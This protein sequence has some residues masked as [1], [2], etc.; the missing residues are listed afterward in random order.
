[1]KKIN[2]FKVKSL[3][4]INKSL[5]KFFTSVQHNGMV[6]CKTSSNETFFRFTGLT[7][8]KCLFVLLLLVEAGSVNATNYYSYQTGNWSSV[9]TWT[10]DPSGTTL[11]N[12]AVPGNNDVI[13]IMPNRTVTLTANVTQ[14]G[15]SI[16]LDEG[17]ILNLSTY[18]TAT[19]LSLSGQG[20]LQLASATFPT[21]TTNTLVNTGGG[22]V[23]YNNTA[24]F[25]LPTGQTSYN[26]LV[27]NLSAGKIATQ[28]N[29]LTLNGDLSVKKGTY[30][31]ND[32]TANRRQLT[33]KGD[34]T[35]ESGASLTVGTGVT[36]STTTPT[37]ITGGTPPF[38]N[39]YNN[40]S[41][42][43]VIN[44]DFTNNGTVRFTN[45]TVPV[46]NAFPPTTVGTTTGFATVYFQGSTDNTV[47]CNG[48]TD[49]Y[50]LVVDK[51]TDKTYVLTLKSTQYN[52]FRLF[53]AN[54]S[55]ADITNATNANPN[56]KKALWLRNGTL[57]LKGLVAIPSLTGGTT[58]TWPSSDFIIPSNAALVLDGTEVVVLSTADDYGEVNVAYGVS[59]GTGSV[60]GVALGGN[61][62]IAVLGKLQINNGY[63]STRESIGITYWSYASGQL[64]INNGML[65]TKQ[66]DDA[67]GSN[68]GLF[69]YAQNNGTVSLRGRFQHSLA[70]S[71]IS[72]LT[73]TA[74]N[75]SRAI[76]G[77]KAT[78]GTIHI[79]TN[80]GSGFSMSGGVMN[81]YDVCGTTTPTYAFYVNSPSANINVTGGTIQFIPITGTSLA[82]ANFLINSAAPFGNLIVNKV[83][84][85]SIVQLNTNPLTVLQSTTIQS[86]TF[87]ANNLNVNIGGNFNV[88]STGVYDS[89]T[90]TTT[91]NG[92]SNQTFTIDGSINNGSA[93]LNNLLINNA[94]GNFK[95][96]GTQTSLTVQGTFD[97][98]SGTL[99]D[100]GKIVYIAGNVTNNGSHTGSGKIQLNGTATQ[101]IGG[102]GSGV[103]QN[104][105]LNNTNA[106]TAPISLTAN[107]TINGTLTFSQAKS[108][109]IGTYGLI[110]NSGASIA[111]AASDRFIQTAG[112]SGDGGITKVYSST[113]PFVFPVG[114][115]STRHTTIFYTPATIGFSSAPT[116]YGSVTVIPVGYEHPA[117][118]QNGQS[119]TYF[120]RIKSS[121]FSGIAT[122]SVTHSFVYTTNDVVGTETKY[123]PSIYNRSNYTWST[124][125][126]ANPPINTTTNTITDATYSTNF[127]DGD[128]TAGDITTNGGAFG[129]QKI[130]YSRQSGLWS[131]ATSWSFTSNT[132]TANTGGVVP[133]A[134]D[135]VV[136]GGNDVITLGSRKTAI[137][138][139]ARNCANLQIEA[140]STL[141]IGNNPGCVFKMVTSHPNGNGNFRLTTLDNAGA[142]TYPNPGGSTFAFPV[143][144]FSE[145]NQNLGTTELYTTN[146]TSGTTYYLPQG[147]TSYG[148]LIIS[149][150]GGSNIIFANNDITIYGNLVTR[151]QN[152]DSWFCP[153]WNVQYPIAP[154]TVVA[155]TITIKGDLL[156][157]GGA[158]VWYGN[159][160]AQN[161]VVNG[162]VVVS[163]GAAIENGGSASNQSLSIGGSLIN[164]T[165]NATASGVSTKS[166][167]D[168]VTNGVIP[169]TFFGS[170]DA[171]ITNTSS[172]PGTI[173]NKVTVNKG[174]S[175]TTTLTCN[176][177]GT[178]TTPTDN[179]L[180]LTNGTFKYARSNPSA[181]A[182][183]TISTGTA[184]TIPATAGLYVNMPSNTNNINVLIANSASNTNDLYLN[185]K[186][187][188]VNGNVYVGP[189]NGTTVNNNDIEYSSGGASAIEV[190]GGNLIVNGS[191][192]RNPANSAGVLSYIQTGGAV[193][194]NGQNALTSNAK[195]EVLNAGSAFNM[196]GGTITIIRGGG[197]TFGDLYLRPT[198][199]SVT[200]GTISFAHNLSGTAQSYGLDANI[201]LNNITITGR[202]T[203]TAANATVN[204]MVSPLVL[205][206]TLL[207][208]NANSI[209]NALN[210]TNSINVTVKGDF[211]NNGTYT[212][213]TNK[214]IFNGGVQQING[215]ST[216]NFYDLQINPIT[217]VTLNGSTTVNH[218]L[219]IN[220]GQ[221]L[222][223][224]N[225]INLKG[226]IT[227]NAS[228]NGDATTG[229][230]ILN[231]PTLQ[232]IAGTGT[233]GRLELNNTMGAQL[234]NNITLQKNFKL[235]TGILD[236]AQYLL[237]LG[238]SSS[239]EGS[240]FSSTKMIV[241]DGVFSNIGIK[242]F[243]S[244]GAST[245]TYPIGTGGKYTPVVLTITANGSVGFVRVNN[246]NAH[247]P[248]VLDANNVL[249]YYW[250]VESSN[251]SGF[252]GNMVFNYLQ[253][254]VKGTETNY[255]AAE[256]M[257]PGTNWSKTT[258][259]NTGTNQI[260]FN[261]LS[262]T[263]TISGQYTGGADAAIPATIPQYISTKT[264]L[265][266]DNTV[267]TPTNGSTY[268]CPAGGP[269]G[270]IVTVASGHVVTTVNYC[271]A[272]QTTINGTLKALTQGNNLGSVYGTG[273]LH[274]ESGS[275]PAGRYTDFFDCGTGGI[276]EFGGTGDYTLVAGYLFASLPKLY[277]IGTGKR[278]MP[279]NDITICT[280]FKIDG[281]TADNSVYNKKIFIGGT[282]ERYNSGVFTSG[283]GSNATVS[284]AGSSAQI[285][286][287]SLGNFSGTNAF[288]N[289][290]INNTAG[291]TLNG[292]TQVKNNLL[293]TAGNITT[294]SANSLT[295]S[296]TSNNC[297]TPAG[298]STTSY[299][300]G[301]LAKT[302]I[303]GDN[304]LFPIGKATNIGNLL[305]L[306]STQTGTQNWTVEYFNPNTYTSFSSPLSSVNSDEY[307]NV[308]STNSGTQQA[309]VNIKWTPS[310]DLNPIMTQSGVSDMTLAKW[311]GANWQ[312]LTSSASGDN[313]N[314]SAQ[315]ISRITIPYTGNNYT[316]GC[317]NQVRPK[318]KFVPTGPVCGTSGIPIN[319]S[320]GATAVAP[321]S[322]SYTINGVDQTPYS[323]T[324]FPAL[325]PTNAAGGVYQITGFTYNYPAG[326]LRTGVFDPTTVT[327]YAIPTTANAGST[328]SLCG[329]T[330]ATLAA[331]T[332]TSGTG[333]W[334]IVSGTGGTVTNPTSPTSTFTGTNGS[335]Y[336]LRW[337][338]SNGTCTSND[339]VVVTFPLLADQPL[340]FT[341]SSSTVCQGAIG[342]VYTVPNDP[343]VTSYNW[344]YSGSGATINGTGNSVTVDF[345]NAATSGT[346]SVTA[347]N[348]CNTST[349]RTINITVN[350]NIWIGTTSS[351][352]WN[353]PT[354]WQAGVVPPS[355][356]DIN[357]ATVPNN[358]LILDGDRTIGNLTN[359]STNKLIIPAGRSL[360]VTNKVTTTN[361][362]QI[363]IQSSSSAPN[364]SLVFTQPTLNSAV[365]ATVEMYSKASAATYSAGKYSN[366]K[367]QYFGI[368]LNSILANPTLAGSYIRI[369]NE[370]GTSSATHW[371]QLHNTDVL[372]SFT[373][374]EI[375]Q[376]VATKI[377]FQGQLVTSDSN[378]GQLSY[379][380][381]SD[382]TFSGQHIFGNPY[383]AAI[384][385]TK[386][387]TSFGSQMDKT[388]YLYNTG[389]FAD[390][391]NNSGISAD[392]TSPGQYTSAPIIWAGTAGIPGQIPS[393]QGF[394]VKALSNSADATFSIPYSSV[395][396]KNTDLQRAPSTQDSTTTDKVYLRITVN[397][398]RFT[399]RMWI[400]SD[401][402]CT[403]SY[404]NGWDG[405]KM[406]GASLSPQLYAI[407]DDG[408]Y[409]VNSVDNI[410]ETYLGFVRGEDTEYKFTFTNENI[411]KRFGNIYL[412]DFVEN[413]VVDITKTGTEYSF[414]SDSTDT[415]VKRFKIVSYLTNVPDTVYKEV[416]VFSSKET[417]YVDNQTSSK[418]SVVLYNMSGVAVQKSNFDPNKITPISTNLP[419]GIYIAK[420]VA[421]SIL[422]SN[423]ILINNP[424]K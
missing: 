232:D 334:T 157:Q 403:R 377:V 244:A 170:N 182:D 179:W 97:L 176:I 212:Y 266:N 100:G 368:P 214:T 118:T 102:S 237:T 81:I 155:K 148:N 400:F 70:Y 382:A 7:V 360:T 303:Q 85:S 200:G 275:L 32:N 241:S 72:D 326:T 151:G 43:V 234:D 409:Q 306:L 419:S 63:L 252:A 171:S 134:D 58:S 167:I 331:N 308:I 173:F 384:D 354:N 404:D 260:T 359:T 160:T 185:G 423:Q 218:N 50:N 319:L 57:N 240:S 115:P 56:V 95:L 40:Q 172:T 371:V 144:D 49:F 288:N 159:S 392:G 137:N 111:N 41:H 251:L 147:V 20:V 417:I 180:T 112:N 279:N 29:N 86:G 213:G 321:F 291:L 388:V 295:I 301:P 23:E 193:T 366:Y 250:E 273:T 52:Y 254:D 19:L 276:L 342:V 401:P 146:S 183:F 413:K 418:G 287:G 259:I 68:T 65:D 285:L 318:V 304:F 6:N 387:T 314:G 283:S 383:T 286:G 230:V 55:P 130:F 75:T 338:I 343:S 329:A 59:G 298:G 5:R 233:F 336:T 150:L 175:Q 133:G 145:F 245:F 34:V 373:G 4:F 116:T 108:F 92:T 302:I 103:F 264:G 219:S 14:T 106:A 408:D 61:S 138:N 13:E 166:C 129:T 407:E 322:I 347:T 378:F 386:L 158:L 82:D 121:G 196:S 18:S 79:N 162:D 344:S 415:L 248:A 33:I 236:L 39:Y 315:T 190:D 362:D 281:P 37:G 45:L 191:I 206:G 349:A 187:T 132:G 110:L 414:Q 217:S 261:Y 268:P 209:L 139:D 346:L 348:G 143:G 364:G 90:N 380:T 290:E 25:T 178:L 222:Y 64:I 389:S 262:G 36:N 391:T 142:P 154:K 300:N 62:G 195:L 272:Y 411:D 352:D 164:N 77:I 174:T 24:N 141:D 1:M 313:Y 140:G 416:K 256:L 271:S 255:W 376:P 412:I 289:L 30:Q 46:F 207:L 297:V 420:T 54:T 66:I 257:V 78:D 294:T 208:S 73:S 88:M 80:S 327:T 53:G 293:L 94:S 310:S 280:Q 51:G 324:S 393:M 11:I 309:I 278:I 3:D 385:I 168:F 351:A 109:Y 410:N 10:T 345:S 332:P 122:N 186:L 228:Y 355:G 381:A 210:G 149:P 320:L 127:L 229:G 15:L 424:K 270:F 197:S 44:G 9:N 243:F 356:A 67:S 189:S 284:F 374:Y 16:T 397:G 394:L 312:Q 153:T 299:V 93:G 379:N 204:L 372:T 120:W 201:P 365:Q 87:D 239:I 406:L 357:F 12:P 328:Q 220:S 199:S 340:D 101:T 282:M 330:S 91:F 333:L 224:T 361:A 8:Q 353:N 152:A 216:T 221:L 405:R 253:A 21:I 263:T 89:G 369:W 307:W 339:D 35:V 227:N 202:T 76:N 399:D 367:W 225:T 123:A 188:V 136:I 47:T 363:Y 96:L 341:V 198:S 99:D 83:S 311:D 22:T 163:T 84:G 165:N 98:T 292:A 242:K 398:S 17:A 181:G 223:G 28:L 215:S 231:G 71:S 117:T 156:I 177:G 135:I 203:A 370:T 113:S 277:L 296:N 421:G 26:N 258:N 350:S 161:I 38:I 192:R 337:T 395:I 235:T 125:T 124:G 375:T 48:T 317:V 42:R 105:E 27:I 60:N 265:W 267:W 2:V 131:A 226:S 247:H 211:T 31:I 396:V 269:N 238:T 169:V 325:L 128:Y 323:P 316:L 390:W 402:S 126:T 249:Q 104:I 422:K 274:L 119:L 184:F 74:L 335:V 305:T 194:I 107:A 205:N 246:I 114:S 69:T 358:D